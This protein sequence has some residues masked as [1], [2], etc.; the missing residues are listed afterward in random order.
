MKKKEV[1]DRCDRIFGI[2]D[3]LEHNGV[4]RGGMCKR[5]AGKL[6]F[7]FN[8]L[9]GEAKASEYFCGKQYPDKEEDWIDFTKKIIDVSFGFGYVVGQSFDIPYPE[10]QKDIEAIKKLLKEKALFPYFPKEGKAA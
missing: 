4:S 9:V 1:L 5:K 8:D 2:I 7:L 10:I 6:K 3:E